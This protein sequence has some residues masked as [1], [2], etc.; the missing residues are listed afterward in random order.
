MAGEPKKKSA[1]KATVASDA[2]A[3]V[4]IEVLRQELEI[5]NQQIAA[6]NQQIVSQN[7][8]MKGLSERLHEGNVLIGSLQQ[9]LALTDGSR[10]KQA[11]PDD[12]SPKGS[13]ASEPP[14]KK[15]PWYRIKIF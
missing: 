12:N 6:Q 1:A 11:S 5:K 2:S 10:N 9:Q 8:L 14:A 7:E 13:I 15:T 4:M 3:S